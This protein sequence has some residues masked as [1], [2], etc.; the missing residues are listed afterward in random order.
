[1]LLAAFLVQFS[2]VLLL[3]PVVVWCEGDDE[4][5]GSEESVDIDAGEED[6]LAQLTRLMQQANM[7]ESDFNAFMSIFG[8]GSAS[9]S[10][11]S[12][13]ST[14]DSI[15]KELDLLFGMQED[16]LS[17]LAESETAVDV[18]FNPMVEF[19]VEGVLLMVVSVFGLVGNTVSIIVLSRPSMRGSFSTL[20]IGRRGIMN[21]QSL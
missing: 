13:I 6:G 5:Y 14:N 4:Y 16:M 8:G 20:L 21:G 1:M 7:S 2:P 17:K 18:Y 3:F 9:S 11:S 15:T 10:S 12:S 19:V